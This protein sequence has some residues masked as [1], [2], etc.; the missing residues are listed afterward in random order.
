MTRSCILLLAGL[1]LSACLDN[2]GPDDRPALLLEVVSAPAGPALPTD[3]LSQPIVVKV[4]D[5]RG[6]A[7]AGVEIAWS[8]DASGSFIPV[9]AVSDQDGLASA[10]WVLGEEPRAQS[11]FATVAGTDLRSEIPMEVEIWRVGQIASGGDRHCALDLAGAAYCWESWGNGKPVPAAAGLAFTAISAAYDHACGLTSAGRVHCWGANNRGQLGDGTTAERATAAVPLL[12]PD[13][14]IAAIASGGDASCAIDV[15]GVGYCWGSL[16]SSS[17]L[18]P[19]PAA[20]PGGLSWRAISVGPFGLCGIE[21]GGQVYCWGR[22]V[23]PFGVMSTSETPALMSPL[24]PFQSVLAGYSAFCGIS[25]RQLSCSA[26]EEPLSVLSGDIVTMAGAG[27]P[28]WGRG[29]PL[30]GQPPA[31]RSRRQLGAACGIELETS[32]LYGWR[33]HDFVSGEVRGPRAV[34]PP[35]WPSSPG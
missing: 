3:T 12:P 24:P 28:N 8:S 16:A 31:Q 1:G 33:E 4:S 9:S 25:G 13:V 32:A 23:D 10:I 15:E 18:G 20:I 6:R 21:S 26:L 11:A 22:L 27:K 30:R 7:A 5:F 29:G 17:L 14:R 34:P 35:G 2:S 19:A